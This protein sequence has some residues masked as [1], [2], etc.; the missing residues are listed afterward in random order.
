MKKKF[1]R[2]DGGNSNNFFLPPPPPPPHVPPS[3]PP[4][5][6][7]PSDLFNISNV[8]RI[9]KFLNNN[10]FNFDFF[11]GYVPPAPNLPLLRRFAGHFFPNRSSAAKMLSKKYTVGTN[12]TQT[13][14]G[15]CL[16]EELKRVIEK[17]NQKKKLFLM[18]MSIF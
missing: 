8:P 12:T 11:D 16:I 5:Q 17:N 13:M 14:S 1:N 10:D 18:K 6:P 7:P 2:G 9:G 3:G 4:Q 15:D